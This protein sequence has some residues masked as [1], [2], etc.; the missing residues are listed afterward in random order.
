MARKKKKKAVAEGEVQEEKKGKKGKKKL[1]LLL[2]PVLLIAVAAAVV[3]FVLPRFGINLLGLGGDDGDSSLA[4]DPLP[5]KGLE[6]YSVGEDS[7][8]S[9]DTIME[10]GEGELIAI[11]GPG[12]NSVD[13]RYT[14]IYEIEFPAQVMNRYLDV[15]LGEEDFVLTDDTYLVSDERP[16]LED[17]EGA[18]ILAH[19]SVVEGHLFQLVIGWSQAN[20]NLAVRVSAPEATLHYP[21][22]EEEPKPVSVTDHLEQ[23]RSMTPAQLGLPGDSMDVYTI[24][25]VD[26]MVKVNGQECR[27]FN[28]YEKGT[29]GGIAGTYLLSGD[30]QHMYV[31][32]PVTNQVN[33]IK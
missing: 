3:I 12:K 24:L 26:G 8:I 14:Y 29:T 21:T 18:L 20:S 5:K 10:E 28:L 31:L 17:A 4:G 9:L 30:G 27:R 6:A 11:R 19:N 25:P 1:L 23:I 7:I 32:D 16:E 15:L 22:P 13:E 33:T 2:L